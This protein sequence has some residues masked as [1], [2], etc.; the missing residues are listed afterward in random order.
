MVSLANLTLRKRI[1]LI[2][3]AGLVVG[4]GLFSWLGIQ[5]LNESTEHIL[6][7]RLTMARIVANHLDESLLHIL[8]HLQ[9]VADATDGLPT[10]E[11]FGPVADSLRQI[12]AESGISARNIILTDRDGRVLQIDPEDARI[13]GG[14]MP[15]YSEVQAVLETGLPTIS[16]LVSSPLI[17]VPVVLATA[18]I[19]NEEGKIIGLLTSSIDIEQSSIGTIGQTI[20]VGETGYTEIV[21]GNG[22]V[23][24]RTEPG[25]P[26]EA[27]EMSDHPGK[28]AAL[29]SQG[30]AITG[31]CHR[32]HETSDALER[33]RDVLAFA[34]LSITSWGV[35]IRQSEEEALAPTQQ[36]ESKLLLLGLIVL[37]SAL[38]LVW[39]MMQGVVK[40]IRMLTAAAKRVAAGDFKAVMPVKRQDEIGQ[41][42][43][44]FYTMTQE[45]ARSRDELV[46]RNRE[47]SVL[48]AIDATVSQSLNLK[49][50]LENALQ[51]VLEVTGTTAGCVFLSDPDSN[52]LEMMTCIGSSNVF[53][54]QEASSAVANCACHQG[55]RYGQTMMVNH[56]SQ[57]PM[58]SGDK[59][60]TKDIGYF[61]S[62][63]IKSKDRTLGI[64][65]VA[66]SSEDGFTEDDFRL[67][68]SIGY[69]VGLAIENAILYE[70]AKQKEKL[71]GQLLSSVIS[72]QEEER[73]RIARELHDELGQTL[74]GLIMSIESSENMTSPE[75]SPLRE[76]LKN[77]KS[78]VVHA[79]ENM[80]RLT[81]NLR[82]SALDD[83]GLT[84]ALRAYTQTH[85]EAVGVQVQFES[86]GLSKRLTPTVETALF[87]IIQEAINNITK[88][89]E[90]DNVRIQLEVKGGK[91]TAIVEDDGRGFDVVAVFKSSGAQSLGLLGIQERATL[92][93]GTFNIKSRIGQGTRLVVEIPIV[94]ADGE[95]N[96]VETKLDRAG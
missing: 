28:F 57:C 3:L 5:S 95:L 92:L 55:L 47:L 35:V 45:L 50:V 62:V 72:A 1:G 19:L 64:M 10:K 90:A 63:P 7:E 18:P 88:H 17:D 79:L 78:L 20:K 82:P 68:D 89:A 49:D 69:H 77:A 11:Q 93:G 75:Q 12:L 74:T 54:C 16:G 53:K 9:N 51:K 81:L 43:T 31:T 34:P 14:D 83:L 2:V 86:K 73:K 91:I 8:V 52:K 94:S 22:I 56:V 42:S 30:K 87:R 84:A 13:I 29:I 37:V 40:P 96:L 66:C 6:N 44:A 48:N 67:L 85:L 38:L 23:L 15:G 27:F 25:S 76:K 59:V 46:S 32:C 24:A 58:L 41:L 80:R 65:N 4:L 36:L 33:R 70:E 71:R 21:D 39:T 26:P 61:A 60:M